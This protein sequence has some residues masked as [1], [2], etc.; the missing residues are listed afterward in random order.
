LQCSS[1]SGMVNVPPL[2]MMRLAP[3][4]AKP[5]RILAH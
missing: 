3:R 1:R 5:Y 2:R 4:A